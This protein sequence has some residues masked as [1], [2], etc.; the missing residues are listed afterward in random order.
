[1]RWLRAAVAMI[2]VVTALVVAAPA[3]SAS[4]SG[5]TNEQYCNRQVCME[6]N[7]KSGGYYSVRA[8]FRTNPPMGATHWGH[9]HLWGPGLDKYTPSQERPAYQWTE[10]FLARG[11]GTVCVEG[12][13]RL[14]GEMKS[15]GLP[16]GPTHT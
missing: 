10:W 2:G 6:V 3:A 5:I 16:C 15:I 8:A 12:W 1:M 9:F 4:S 13:S 14:Y 11:V 7:S